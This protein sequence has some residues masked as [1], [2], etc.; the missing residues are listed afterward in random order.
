MLTPLRLPMTIS[1]K[2]AA[3]PGSAGLKRRAHEV[4]TSRNVVAMGAEPVSV[5]SW[6]SSCWY[7][8]SVCEYFCLYLFSWVDR[9]GLRKHAIM[10]HSQASIGPM[11]SKWR[12]NGSDGVSDH[13]PH[14]CLVNRLFRRRSLAFVRVIHRWPVNSPRKRPVT[15]K[16]FVSIWWRHH[17]LASV[18][19]VPILAPYDMFTGVV[20]LVVG[21]N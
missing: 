16:M 19:T 12:H 20:S 17:D 3:L 11:P 21:N 15:R 6:W 13:Q 14:H 4:M 9:Q 2:K 7:F 8:L 18:D 1:S 5:Q 10:C